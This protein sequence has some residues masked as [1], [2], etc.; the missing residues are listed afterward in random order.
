MTNPIPFDDLS[1]II[2]TTTTVHKVGEIVAFE[3]KHYRLIEFIGENSSYGTLRY[4]AEIV[5]GND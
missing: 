2:V 4:H 1:V 3:G 5:H